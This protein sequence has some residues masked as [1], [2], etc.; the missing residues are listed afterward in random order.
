LIVESPSSTIRFIS[1]KLLSYLIIRSLPS[2]P[3]PIPIQL[4]ILKDLITSAPSKDLRAESVSILRELVINELSKTEEE[5]EDEEKSLVEGGWFL[6]EFESIL[7]KLGEEDEETLGIAGENFALTMK[8][9]EFY[10]FLICKDKENKVSLRHTLFHLY[11]QRSDA[12]FKTGVLSDSSKTYW[13]QNLLHPL[14]KRLNV[15]KTR[16]QSTEKGSRSTEASESQLGEKEDFSFEID[17][18]TIQMSLIE[19]KLNKM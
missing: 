17:A 3:S 4:L 6:N 11:V 5:K 9:I 1:L 7:G 19:A 12:S 8:K 14:K 10:Y 13:D 2:H 16:Q 18:L 15:L